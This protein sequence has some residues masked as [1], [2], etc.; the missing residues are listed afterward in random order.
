MTAARRC[1]G[2]GH[3]HRRRGRQ[4]GGRPQ[5]RERRARD[6]RPGPP[7]HGDQGR[8]PRSWTARA[9]PSAIS[10]RIRQIRAEIEDDRLG[11][12]P[13][14]AAGAAGEALRRR[15]RHPGRC[16]DR[17]GAEGEEAPPRGRDLG[18]PGRDRG[19][20]RRRRRQRARARRGAARRPRPV[21]RRGDRRRVVR[22][23]LVE[24]LR[25]IAQN[26]GDEGMVVVS[27]GRATCRPGRASTPPPASTAT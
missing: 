13:G 1:C 2:H 16:R 3:P 24:P 17:G 19:G 27:Q 7:R 9:T 20:H 6:A 8:R 15:R 26:A 21:R 18:D 12:G 5:A 23:A 25:W 14:E 4:R 22:T 11:L 10:D